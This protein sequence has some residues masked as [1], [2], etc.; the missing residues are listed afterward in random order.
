[1]ILTLAL[2][3]FSHDRLRSLV[4][5]VGIVFAVVLL[6]VQLG[7]YAGASRMITG[8]VDNAAADLWVMPFGTQSFDEGVP[9]LGPAER[10]QVLA[11]DGVK[12]ATPLVVGF[13]DW[14]R[15]DSATSSVVVVGADIE[16]ESLRPWQ[17]SAGGMENLKEPDGVGVD[18]SYFEELGIAGL[19]DLGHVE[20]ERARVRLITE[21]IRSFTQ[22][23]YIFTT[24]HRARNM[25]GAKSQASTFLLVRT[26]SDANVASVRSEIAG[27]LKTAEVL[28][29]AEFRDRNLQQWLFNTG[30]GVALIGGAILGLIV[31]TVIVSQ[32]L[33]SSTK[34]H[35]R[36]Y[37]T[38]RALGS[39]SLYLYKVVITQA[40]LCAVIGYTLGMIFA[41]ILV[42]ASQETAMQIVVS[43]FLAIGLF[44]LTVGMAGIAAAAAIVKVMD[45]DPASVFSR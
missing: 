8:A 45:I 7:L 9:L 34:D 26:E 36:E 21:G 35:L 12:A 10:H 16:T 17:I 22:S 25:F 29:P 37:A 13:A 43:P 41:M 19:G 31:G 27:R 32:T 24:A 23:P 30:A 20:G 38:L 15:P 11:V 28:T 5:I 33:Y 14:R 40:A 39:P 18:R 6:A 44:M 4:T 3:N 42:R 2:R 1:M